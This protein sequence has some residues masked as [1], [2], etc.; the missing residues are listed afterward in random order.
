MKSI[1][2]KR[3]DSTMVIC[4]P[5]SVGK[6]NFENNK[7]EHQKME[8]TEDEEL[9]S[10]YRQLISEIKREEFNRNIKSL[11]LGYL[12]YNEND[13]TGIQLIVNGNNKCE[14]SISFK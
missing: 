6:M 5:I 10:C 7:W 14:M 4:S 12:G 2:V 3:G 9:Q 8:L 13:V 11:V 1:T